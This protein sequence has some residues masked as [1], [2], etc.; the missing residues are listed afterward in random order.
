[1]PRL[2][3]GYTNMEYHGIPLN[4]PVL[5]DDN[6]AYHQAACH[7]LFEVAKSSKGNK[8]TQKA[9]A[10]DLKRFLN[11]ISP[12]SDKR[13]IYISDFKS[14]TDNQMNAY[15]ISL[16]MEGLS[17][18]SITRHISTI[19]EFYRFAFRNGYIDDHRIFTF[20]EA[21]QGVRLQFA[22][23]ATSQIL[24]QFIDRDDFSAILSHVVAKSAFGRLRNELALKCGYHIGVRTEELVGYDNFSVNK[25]KSE[26]PNDKTGFLEHGF[27][28]IIGK[29]HKL[30]SVPVCLDLKKDLFRFL[31]GDLSNKI[32]IHLFES[33]KGQP[34]TD[35][36]YG[37]NTFRRAKE[38]FLATNI[39][40]S[41]ERK[42]FERWVFHSLR[43][44]CATNF[45]T[46]CEDMDGGK[47]DPF[48]AIPQWM[49]H[50]DRKT[51]ELYV[52]AEALLKRRLNV[53]KLM[54]R[55][56]VEKDKE[57]PDYG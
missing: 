25:L 9:R 39:I 19:M 23:K 4:V 48:L 22:D 53:L 13:H 3:I 44:T 37:S 54:D 36:S 57:L 14:I 2:N 42:S 43:H 52:C 34:L 30:R 7:F 26:F 46:Y 41:K 32:G 16:Q 11:A 15:L 31:Y 35:P 24:S 1:M 27:I 20:N 33:R 51:T 21:R 6:Y 47:Y 49:G 50:N 18:K 12:A 45:V 38:K 8:N 56:S 5:H 28:K 40:P 55:M 29:G 10:S 17:E